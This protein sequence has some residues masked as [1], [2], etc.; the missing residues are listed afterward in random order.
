MIANKA[1]ITWMF[2]SFS[3]KM[4]KKDQQKPSGERAGRAQLAAVL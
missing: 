4:P 1:Y 3:W 2:D